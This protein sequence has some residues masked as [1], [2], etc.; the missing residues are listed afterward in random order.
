MRALHWFRNDL[1][2]HDNTALG[3]AAERAEE[4]LPVFV[5]DPH[6]VQ[7]RCGPPRSEMTILAAAGAF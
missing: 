1:R 3:A 4:L 7:H 2:L 5:V 6:L